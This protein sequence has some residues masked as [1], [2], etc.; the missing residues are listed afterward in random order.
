MP[1]W[2]RRPASR[3]RTLIVMLG[4]VSIGFVLMSTMGAAWPVAAAIAASMFCSIFC[5]AGN[6]AVYAIV[7]LVKKRVSGQISGLAGAYGNVGSIIFLSAFLYV[8]PTVFFLVIAGASI[9]STAI[10]FFWLREPAAS[11]AA[12]LLTDDTVADQPTRP[13]AVDLT[14]VAA[15]PTPVPVAGA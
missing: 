8:S 4:G 15:R 3:R 10:S 14:D 9:L 12:E 11:F 1:R 5:Q 7:P 2:R 13:V 6:G